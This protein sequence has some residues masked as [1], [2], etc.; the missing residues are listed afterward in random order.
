MLENKIE[1][2]F[3]LIEK[4]LMRSDEDTLYAL[5]TSTIIDKFYRTWDDSFK[6]EYIDNLVKKG[7]SKGNEK[8]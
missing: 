8:L 7:R 6:K 5:H 2:Y 4:E 3:K 1:F